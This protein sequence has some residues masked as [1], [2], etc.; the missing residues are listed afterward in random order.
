MQDLFYFNEQDAIKEM[1]T[2]LVQ[3]LRLHEADGH[4]V[5]W[6]SGFNSLAPCT[7]NVSPIEEIS[8]SGLNEEAVKAGSNVPT[9]IE[10]EP[11]PIG[12]NGMKVWLNKLTPNTVKSAELFK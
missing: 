5:E 9:V 12:C 1:I 8:V 2:R 10:G 6:M 3:G 7:A 4:L 11:G